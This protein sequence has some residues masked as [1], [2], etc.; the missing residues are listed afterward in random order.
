MKRL[1]CILL[2]LLC[3][4]AAC[5]TGGPAEDSSAGSESLPAETSSAPPTRRYAALGDSIARGYGLDD[6]ETQAYPALLRDRM[7][8]YSEV[9]Y[10]NYAVDGQTSAGLLELLSSGGAPMLDGA[11]VV[12]VCIGANNLLGPTIG[13]LSEQLVE[14][15]LD[16]PSLLRKYYEA[17]TGGDASALEEV[18]S[19]LNRLVG[20][21]SAAL[22]EDEFQAELQAGI[23]DMS[24]HLPQIIDAIRRQAPEAD[25]YVTTVYNPYKGYKITLGGLQAE[26]PLDAVAD[27]AVRAL[28]AVITSQADALSYTVAD[29]YT[30]F[31]NSG[32]DLVN[33]GANFS[34]DPHPNRAGH[35]LLAETHAEKI[36]M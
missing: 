16:M 30:A 11:D 33:A 34:V 4:L 3:L 17:I 27:N 15:A 18:R 24:A 19:D 5:T 32:A 7:Q 22:E 25:I 2:S 14:L 6:P 23:Q 21:L 26:L 29:S 28:N 20:A 36:R 10:A 12:T 13:L 1:F 8:S 31:E 9:E 35:E